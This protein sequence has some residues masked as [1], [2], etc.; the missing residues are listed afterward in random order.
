MIGS[1]QGEVYTRAWRHTSLPSGTQSMQQT[2]LCSAPR[3]DMVTRLP[4]TGTS[5]ER[6][7]LMSNVSYADSRRDI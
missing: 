1:K 5:R 4:G 7:L 3:C 2:Y 6:E